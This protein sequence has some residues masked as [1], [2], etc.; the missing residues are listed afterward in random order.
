MCVDGVVID[1]HVLLLEK[2]AEHFERVTSS[3]I[4][5]V[6]ELK[7]MK[8][9]VDNLL[10]T[11]FTMR[12]TYWMC[13]LLL[14]EVAA[15]IRRLKRNKA[16][17]PDGE[18][19]KYAGESMVIWLMNIIVEMEMVPD[20]MKMGIVVPGGGKDPM[21]F[22]SYRGITLM[23]MVSKELGRLQDSLQ[24]AGIPH[25]NQTA[26]RKRVRMECLLPKK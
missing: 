3:K 6:K 21:K 19:L 17:G 11:S 18:H 4:G 23:S 8:L 9:K 24:M 25:I 10:P 5:F 12:N 22:D 1:D 14:M 26:Y 16:A 20:F 15:A 7:K 13:I 2:W